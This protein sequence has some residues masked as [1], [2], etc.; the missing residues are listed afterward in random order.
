MKKLPQQKTLQQQPVLV[1]FF[2]GQAQLFQKLLPIFAIFAFF[3]ALLL[4]WQIFKHAN[5]NN[6]EV[7]PAAFTQVYPSLPR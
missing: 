6:F 1:E 7:S 2:P 5:G 3:F 4:I